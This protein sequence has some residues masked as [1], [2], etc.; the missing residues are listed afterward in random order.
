MPSTALEASKQKAA[1][2]LTRRELALLLREPAKGWLDTR[3]HQRVVLGAKRIY[4]AVIASRRTYAKVFVAM[5]RIGDETVKLLFFRFGQGLTTVIREGVTLYLEGV[6]KAGETGL[7]MAQPKVMSFEEL[8]RPVF[9]PVYSGNVDRRQLDALVA[10]VMDGS[11]Y[12]DVPNDFLNREGLLPFRDVIQKLHIEG[13]V[14]PE[15][16]WLDMTGAAIE[17]WLLAKSLQSATKLEREPMENVSLGHREIEASETKLGFRLTDDQRACLNE[18]ANMFMGSTIAG[19]MVVGD[20]GTG[21]SLVAAI[22]AKAVLDAG[23]AVMVMEPNA[24]LATQIADTFRS[25]GIEPQIVTGDSKEEPKSPCVIGTH[26]ILH[27]EY[28][29]ARQIGL[30]IVDETQKFGVAQYLKPFKKHAKARLLQMTATPLP[31][32]MMRSRLGGMRVFAMKQT[33][34]PRKVRTH[35]VTDAAILKRAVVSALNNKGTRMFI[36]HPSIGS[37][38]MESVD[39]TYR[40]LLNMR[41]LG[42]IPADTELVVLHGDMDDGAKQQALERFV[43][44]K[45]SAALICTSIVEIGVDCE[46]ANMVIVR[47]AARHG[48]SQLHQIRGRV[49]R[50]G[51]EGQC[52]LYCDANAKPDVHERLRFFASTDDGFE[53]ADFDMRIRGYGDLIGLEQKG[54]IMRLDLTNP[55]HNHYFFSAMSMIECG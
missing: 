5:A 3:V 10:G 40:N 39:R 19:A 27:R 24:I 54:R 49:G 48:L 26:A 28:K 44:A 2:P 6:V 14:E 47:D 36:V 11:L 4:K 55:M 32:S 12:P 37:N 31:R 50:H 35:V 51:E 13:F 46:G 42:I 22:A 45:G 52:I 1:R 25:I 17:A 7:E 15:R 20:V 23:Y 33:P 43:G 9:E 53:I 21:K 34:R 8:P 41:N 29:G 30:V 38:I 16:H 18:I